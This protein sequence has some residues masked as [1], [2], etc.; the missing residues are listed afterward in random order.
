MTPQERKEIIKE[1]VKYFGKAREK[2]IH[3][4]TLN[5]EEIKSLLWDVRWYENNSEEF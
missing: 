4:Y 1:A 5:P 3:R 2:L